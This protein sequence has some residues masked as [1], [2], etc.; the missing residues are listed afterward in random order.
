MVAARNRRRGDPDDSEAHI[1]RRTTD[2]DAVL[3][4][5]SR[6]ADCEES[7]TRLLEA[8]REM[9]ENMRTLTNNMGRIAEVLEA[10]NNAKGF[11]ITIKFVSAFARVA[12]PLMAFG[13]AL[14]LFVKTGQWADR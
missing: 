9:T 10:W 5:H 6:V 1:H 3:H 8:Q 7:I 4:L 12:L 11:W 14:W 2:S 13:A